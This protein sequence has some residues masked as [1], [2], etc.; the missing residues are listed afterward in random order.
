MKLLIIPDVHGRQF[1]KDILPFADECGKI[2]FLGDYHDPYLYEG[3]DT[4]QSLENFREIIDFANSH[5]DK[6]TLL[7]GNHDLSYCHYSVGA[8]RF[9]KSNR[10]ELEKIFSD[11]EKL[12]KIADIC[13]IPENG[14]VFLFSHAGIQSHWIESNQLIDNFDPSTTDADTIYNTVTQCYANHDPSFRCALCDVSYY[15]GGYCDSGSMVW[16]D[17][18]EFYFQPPTPYIQIF[19]HTQQLERTLDMSTNEYTW[20]PTAP[21]VY[22]NNICVDCHTCFYIDDDGLLH[23]LKSNK[24]II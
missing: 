7:L 23:D 17:S 20:H 4:S 10:H 21:S 13:K 18:H 15:R 24:V 3:I 14:K 1:W 9:D 6:V 8:N 19:G 12:F 11:N 5:S 22:G 2:V 16:G